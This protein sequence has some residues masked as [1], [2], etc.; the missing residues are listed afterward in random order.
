MTLMINHLGHFLL[1]QNL[2][3]LLKKSGPGSR[4][5][6]VSSGAHDTANPTAFK[7]L[8]QLLVDGFQGYPESLDEVTEPGTLTPNFILDYL[9]PDFVLEEM[10]KAMMQPQMIRFTVDFAIVVRCLLV[11]NLIGI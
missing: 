7:D 5:I 9:M 11:R 2:L 1:T 3:D 8:S 6:N 4:I 10:F